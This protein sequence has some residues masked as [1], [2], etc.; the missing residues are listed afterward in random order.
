[1]RT[2]K[3]RDCANHRLRGAFAA[4]ELN[5]D[6]LWICHHQRTFGGKTELAGHLIMIDDN[7]PWHQMHLGQ[8]EDQ[9]TEEAAVTATK[10]MLVPVDGRQSLHF[11]DACPKRWWQRLH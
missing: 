6:L 8:K 2:H 11:C 5:Q 4:D 7:L 3:E 10:Q 1:M 9:P